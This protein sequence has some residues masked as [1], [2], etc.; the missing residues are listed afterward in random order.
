M[1]RKAAVNKDT[2]FE[3]LSGY[4]C[5]LCGNSGEICMSGLVTPIGQPIPPVTGYCICPNG[6]AIKWAVDRMEAKEKP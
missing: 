3:F 5:G 2:W 1:V 6:R 4:I